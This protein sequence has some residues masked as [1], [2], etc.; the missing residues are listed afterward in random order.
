MI[1][2]VVVIGVGNPFRRDDGVGPAV[3]EA[4]RTQVPAGTL[5]TVSDGEPGRMLGLWHRD[6]EVVVVEAVHAHPGQPGRLL[7]LRAEQAEQAGR[8]GRAAVG[9][10]STH[11]L[12]LGE[13]FAL[14]AALDRM[15]RGLVVHAVEGADFTLGVGLSPAVRSAL[16]ELTRQVADAIREAHRTLGRA[17]EDTADG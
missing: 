12:G 14:A 5:L 8:A 9:S 17:G 1:G 10:A 4:V 11:A 15:P 16:P 7:T 3:I 13:T 6:D 2:R